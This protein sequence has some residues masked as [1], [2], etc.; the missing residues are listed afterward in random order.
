MKHS[1]ANNLGKLIGGFTNMGKKYG[2]EWWILIA[3]ALIIG[4]IML[5][6]LHGAGHRALRPP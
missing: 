1:P 5:M 4:G 3:G 6:A 2:A